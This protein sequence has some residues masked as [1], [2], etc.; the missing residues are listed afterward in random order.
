M[1]RGAAYLPTS[2]PSF[3]FFVFLCYCV[4][5]QLWTL[6][7]NP[8]ATIRRK[9]HDVLN[10]IRLQHSRA[11]RKCQLGIFVNPIRH[12]PGHY[13]R[14]AC[15]IDRLGQPAAILVWGGIAMGVLSL[16]VAL[17]MKARGSRIG[18][19]G[20]NVDIRW[21]VHGRCT[22]GV[23]AYR[24]T[25]VAIY[26]LTWVALSLSPVSPSSHPSQINPLN[27]GPATSVYISEIFPSRW[28]ANDIGTSAC[29]N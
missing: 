14:R 24:Y 6:L 3:S 19:V 7:P 26:S 10:R 2:L 29:A 25:L 8:A 1:W 16:A 15:F 22:A 17:L 13:C 18:E 21:R 11:Y 28:R 5:R 20:S 23:I 12:L 27:S 4:T 9:Y